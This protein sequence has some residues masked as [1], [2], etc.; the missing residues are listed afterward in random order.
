MMGQHSPIRASPGAHCGLSRALVQGSGDMLG[1]RR[2]SLGGLCSGRA[3]S[4]GGSRERWQPWALEED[5]P[6]RRRRATGPS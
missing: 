3:W 5:P 2:C 4:A 6:V 1:G